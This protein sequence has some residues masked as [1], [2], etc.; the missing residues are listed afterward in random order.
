[1]VHLQ[2]QSEMTIAI[3]NVEN[4]KDNLCPYSSAAIVNL[5]SAY[6]MLWL[7]LSAML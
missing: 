1:M 7:G 5:L 4:I 6:T 2:L 3:L